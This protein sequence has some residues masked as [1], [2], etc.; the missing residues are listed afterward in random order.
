M[1]WNLLKYYLI[2]GRYT[3]LERLDYLK[4]TSASVC[5]KMVD[6]LPYIRQIKQI[7]NTYTIWVNNIDIQDF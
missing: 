1:E 7:K 2:T 3:G 4:V 6:E 5:V